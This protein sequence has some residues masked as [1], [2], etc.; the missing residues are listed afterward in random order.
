M[1]ENLPPSILLFVLSDPALD[2]PIEA[3]HYVLENLY[4]SFTV[5]RLAFLE[6]MKDDES[7]RYVF[8]EDLMQL[9]KEYYVRMV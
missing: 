6:K 7:Q 1:I 5:S 2:V 8:E 4:R 3:Y 9:T